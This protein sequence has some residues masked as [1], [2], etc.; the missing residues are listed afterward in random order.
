MFGYAQSAIPSWKTGFCPPVHWKN[1]HS[2]GG[3]EISIAGLSFSGFIRMPV[4][5]QDQIAA[6]ITQGT[7]TGSLD[8]VKAEAE[9]RLRREWQ[10]RGYFKAEVSTDADVLSSNP[11]IERIALNAHLEEGPRYHLKHI[12]FTNNK[13][14][15]NTKA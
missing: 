15:P 8:G 4:S 11:A 9:E 7:Y 6:S 2:S 3:P 1:R 14:V 12:T 10:K 13:V 5:D